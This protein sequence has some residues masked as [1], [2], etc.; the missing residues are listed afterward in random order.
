MERLSRVE[1]PRL[2]RP[3]PPRSDPAIRERRATR[4]LR[5]APKAAAHPG[6]PS[7]ARDALRLLRESG[8]RGATQ[9]QGARESGQLPAGRRR[10]PRAHDPEEGRRLRIRAARWA[11][12]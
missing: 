9:V 4:A 12:W 6:S 7:V 1:P 10:K 5:I 2:R 8:E 11:R 3:P